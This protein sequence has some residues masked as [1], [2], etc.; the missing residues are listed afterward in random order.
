M[1]LVST[2]AIYT[3]QPTANIRCWLNI[4]IPTGVAPGTPPPTFVFEGQTFVANATLSGDL[5]LGAFRGMYAY[6]WG[7]DKVRIGPMV[8]LGV[9]TTKLAI[10]GTTNNGVRSAEDSISKFAATV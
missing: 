3:D 8:D 5:N 7:N 1:S 9:I 2:C 10:S 4:P 6:R